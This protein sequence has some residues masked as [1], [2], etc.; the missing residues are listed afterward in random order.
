MIQCLNHLRMYLVVNTKGLIRV[1]HELMH[2]ERGIVW[3]NDGV[4]NLGRWHHGESSHHPVWELFANLGDQQCTHTSTSTTT[5][6]VSNLESLK[7][8][9]TFS[10]TTDNIEDLVDQFSTLGVVTFRPVISSTGLAE[11]E[12]VRTEELA[13]GTSTNSVHSTCNAVR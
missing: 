12:I 8:V 9:A 7:T 11:N 6:R 3:L 5:K 10:L 4:G 1:L 2:R 13:E